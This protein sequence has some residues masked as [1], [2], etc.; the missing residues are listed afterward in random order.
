MHSSQWWEQFAQRNGPQESWVF[1]YC[2]EV[3]TPPSSLGLFSLVS[4][5][6]PSYHL[7]IEN[8]K[9]DTLSRQIT[10]VDEDRPERQQCWKRSGYILLTAGICST[11]QVFVPARIHSEVHVCCHS[12]QWRFFVHPIPTSVCDC[13]TS[14]TRCLLVILLMELCLSITHLPT[15]AVLIYTRLLIVAIFSTHLQISNHLQIAVHPVDAF[16]AILGLSSCLILTC[17]SKHSLQFYPFF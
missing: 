8:C 13:L 3:Q 9:P 4:T 1:P 15:L 10:T 16:G 7:G 12:F 6:S 2:Q 14:V 11:G 17:S 5:S